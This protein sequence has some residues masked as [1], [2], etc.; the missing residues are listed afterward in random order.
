MSVKRIIEK[1]QLNTFGVILNADREP[2]TNVFVHM[3]H[4]Y[5]MGTVILDICTILVHM[6]TVILDP[7]KTCNRDGN[8]IFKYMNFFHL[9]CHNFESAF[10]CSK[11]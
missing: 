2:N 5:H 11:E 1:S 7:S 10:F 3:V 8:K 6:G 9:C 4:M